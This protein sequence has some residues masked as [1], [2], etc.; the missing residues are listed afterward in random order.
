M[1]A[2]M[3]NRSTILSNFMQIRSRGKHYKMGILNMMMILGI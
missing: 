1:L 2:L 3:M